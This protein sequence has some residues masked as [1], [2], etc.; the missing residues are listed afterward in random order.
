MIICGSSEC[1]LRTSTDNI[2]FVPNNEKYQDHDFCSYGYKLIFV[3]RLYSK[4]Y[5]TCCGED[6]IDNF[7]NDK[8]KEGEYYS[9]IIETK[10]NTPLVMN[11]KIMEILKLLLRSGKK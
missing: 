1:I 11:K 3:G 10:F 5:K 4:P 6:A 8:I 9:K 2:G 7:L